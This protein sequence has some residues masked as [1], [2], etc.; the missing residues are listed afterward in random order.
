M[1]K[2]MAM[3]LTICLLTSMLA[4]TAT[5]VTYPTLPP[6][7][8]GNDL[9]AV[10]TT[11]GEKIAAEIF[12]TTAGGDP[13][14]DTGDRIMFIDLWELFMDVSDVQGMANAYAKAFAILEA[15][16]QDDRLVRM[17]ASVKAVEV[18]ATF[19]RT[20]PG[21]FTIDNAKK[22]LGI[23]AVD[24]NPKAFAAAFDSRT[25]D[26]EAALKIAGVDFNT[27][28]NGMKRFDKVCTFLYLADTWHPDTFILNEKG[29]ATVTDDEMSLDVEQCKKVVVAANINL[30]DKIE[31]IDNAVL[32][33]GELPEYYNSNISASDKK[34]MLD[35]LDTYNFVQH[36][37]KYVPT[38]TPAQTSASAPAATVIINRD[39]TPQGPGAFKLVP[40]VTG[41]TASVIFR[42]TDWTP[43]KKD[44]TLPFIMLDGT[45]T[46]AGLKDF[47]F[48]IEYNVLKDFMSSTNVVKT[49]TFMTNLGNVTV[50]TNAFDALVSAFIDTET[51]AVKDSTVLYFKIQKTNNTNEFV[52]T[53]TL[54]KTIN[55]VKTTKVLTSDDTFAKSVILALTADLP[56]EDTSDFYTLYWVKADGSLENMGGIYDADAKL[57]KSELT[58]FSTYRI[59]RNVSLMGDLGDA[60]WAA[61]NIRNL[62][63]AGIVNGNKGKFTPNGYVT[64][65]EFAKMIAIAKKLP[66]AKKSKG[67]KDIKGS[68][69]YQTFV[70]SAAEA[71]YIQG[72]GNSFN[73][74]KKI[75]RQDIAVIL[76]KAMGDKAPEATFADLTF[77]DK[78]SISNYARDAV[79]I[80]VEANIMTGKSDNTV[81][82]LGNATRAEAA[83]MIY[84]F[85]VYILS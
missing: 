79:A 81:N 55:G 76:V 71:G 5:A 48:G 74:G 58:H 65:A 34:A 67:F 80:A 10:P 2:L 21:A 62:I 68:D 14:F 35:Y 64:R 4:A 41:T 75:T 19:M 84:R 52:V 33:M 18:F 30:K 47:T 59:S 66:V 82:P 43:L 77:T 40:T 29:T 54:E 32:A 1:R 61:K 9:P 57:F 44:Y 45:A 7:G 23:D 53:L 39:P 69:W 8:A 25:S 28:L 85:L 13:V 70:D 60:S 72:D 50:P 37:N 78:D 31:G 20:N 26:F 38:P 56:N 6:V 16:N 3:V 15:Y 73:P 49:A 11:F 17:G 12:A 24:Q 22:Y 83:A 36:I 27:V 51:Q 42:M 46:E 63:G